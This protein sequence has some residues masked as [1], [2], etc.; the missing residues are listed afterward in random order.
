MQ[1]R[2]NRALAISLGLHIVAMLVVSPFLIHH[3]NIE[4]ERISAEILAP[5][6]PRSPIQYRAPMVLSAPKQAQ[7]NRPSRYYLSSR[8]AKGSR[9]IEKTTTTVEAH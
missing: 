3:F 6:F 5:E 9:S 4:K 8:Q 2:T 1:K 7:A